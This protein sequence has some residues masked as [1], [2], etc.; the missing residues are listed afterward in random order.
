MWWP[1]KD[2]NTPRGDRTRG[3]G[4][5][6]SAEYWPARCWHCY[7]RE[8][9]E[10]GLATCAGRPEPIVIDASPCSAPEAT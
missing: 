9:T 5:L 8:G 4:H 10:A 7:A 2:P 6:W 3:E 1:M